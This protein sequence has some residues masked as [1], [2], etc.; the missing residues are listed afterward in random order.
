[1]EDLATRTEKNGRGKE[2]TNKRNNEGRREK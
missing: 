2:K 1:V